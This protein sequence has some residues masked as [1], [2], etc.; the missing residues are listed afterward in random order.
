MVRARGAVTQP[1]VEPQSLWGN[2]AAAAPSSP[3]TGFA[4]MFSPLRIRDVELRNRLVFQPHFTALGGRD[5]LVSR[6]HTAYHE[7]RARGGVGLIVFESQAVHPSGKMSRR[8]V[9]AWDPAVLPGYRTL[10]DAVHGHGAKIFGQLTHGG[11]TS[12]EN[13]PHLMW[14]PSQMPEPSSHFTTKAMDVDDIRAV[15]DGF[16][17]SARNA[18]DGGFDGVEIK[19]AHDGLLRSF[20]S[21]FFNHRTDGYGGS[22]EN[23]MRL[24]IEVLEAVRRA[25]RPDFPIGVRLCLHEFTTFGY[26]LAYGLRMAEALEA[27][28]C[29]DYFNADAGSFSSYWMEIP[30]AAV[31]AGTFRSL[32]AAL[33]QQSRLPVVAFGRIAPPSLG[34]E[35]LT[36]GEADLIGFA[37][38]LIADPATPNKLREGRAHLVRPCIA[39]N[40]ACIYQV[41]QEKQIRCVHNPAAGREDEVSERVLP[42][43]DRAGHVVVVGGGPVGMKVAETARRRGHI[44]TLL[45]RGTALGGQVNLAARQP[46]H[47]HIAGVTGY[48]AA[49]IGDLGVAVELGVE[50]TPANLAARRPDILVIATGSEPN[51]P[52]RAG[53][54]AEDNGIARR[55]GRHVLPVLPGLDLPMVH[56]S[57]EVLSGAVRLAGRVVVIDLNG[58]WEAAGTVEFLADQGCD[59]EHVTPS[60]MAGQDLEG[61]TRTL[62]YRRAAMKRVRLRTATTVTA[63]E[64]GRV[65]VR[66]V[67]GPQRSDTWER[68]LIINGEPEWIEGVDAVV[69]VVG[70]RSREDL[71]HACKDFA[72]LAGVRVERVGDCVAPRLVESNI[73]EAH[74]L[75]LQL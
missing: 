20:A 69:A 22:F 30:P 49:S 2:D 3:A 26:D 75:A 45:E 11:H 58:H 41:G 43:I 44:V 16:A 73:A 29:V 17:A 5:G 19:V 59:V 13:P 72:G 31:R 63:I 8:F 51:L 42:P 38:Q 67:F 1:Q 27:T 60:L 39:C 33:K 65:Q 12:L 28:G 70:R 10:T 54:R 61:G 36:S 15:V 56:S 6:A 57:E 68:Y 53:R 52:G 50:A 7:E 34:E 4:V 46:E 21:P 23:R 24:S 32:N 48:L 55:L 62:F 14:A 47:Q 64:P 66:A 25:T 35:M 71:Y 40:D 37:R 74:F 18:M 9:S